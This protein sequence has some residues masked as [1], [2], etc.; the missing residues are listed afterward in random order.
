MTRDEAPRAAP[1][2]PFPISPTCQSR[3]Q[4]KLTR[5]SSMKVMILFVHLQG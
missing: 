2:F 3:G 4:F 5:P 1:Y